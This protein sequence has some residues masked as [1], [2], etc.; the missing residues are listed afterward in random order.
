[1]IDEEALTQMTADQLEGQTD[2]LEAD[3]L[4]GKRAEAFLPMDKF[5]AAPGQAKMNQ[6][7]RF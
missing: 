7:N 6:T 1:M 3:V 2:R 4:A 5:S